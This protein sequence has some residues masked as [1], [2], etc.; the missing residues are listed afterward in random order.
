MNDWGPYIPVDRIGVEPGEP[1]SIPPS[2][3][4]VPRTFTDNEKKRVK[5]DLNFELPFVIEGLQGKVPYSH[6]LEGGIEVSVFLKSKQRAH[7]DIKAALR[8]ADLRP[9]KTG[10]IVSHGDRYGRIN[11]SLIEFE[12]AAF[13]DIEQAGW[14]FE[15]CLN[16]T[17][18]FIEI[19]RRAKQDFTLRRLAKD[20]IFAYIMVHL[21]E[22]S[23]FNE[24]IQPVADL[25]IQALG[26]FPDDPMV[27]PLIWFHSQRSTELWNRLID[28]A[29]HCLSLE[30]Y[31]MAVVNSITALESVLKKAPGTNV[32]EFFERY[33]VPF[34]RWNDRKSRE[35]IT[36]CLN[37]FN[38]LCDKVHLET[39]LTERI[40][41]HY[42][43]RNSIVH[44]GQMN[45]RAEDGQKCVADICSFIRYLLDLIHLSVT[46]KFEI[47]K[48]PNPDDQFEL[49]GMRSDE[50]LLQVN[51][52]GVLFT[53]TLQT[54]DGTTTDVK[55][56]L[57]RAEWTTG[58]TV[59]LSVTYDAHTEAVELLFDT[60]VMDS[61]SGC[62]HGCVDA[63]LLRPQVIDGRQSE[64]L[65]IQA[66]LLHE[67]VVQ[68]DEL[69]DLESF[70]RAPE[71]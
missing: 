70:L 45:V 37:L 46:L 43:R 20:D 63:S 18:R 42:A 14:L 1:I 5:T 25:S 16:W 38:L 13:F 48:L 11:V 55:A 47:V 53:V 54:A 36:V 32:K 19:Y 61:A 68:A 24:I 35:S 9:P 4:Y 17:N 21:Y 71:Q 23:Q 66:I 58:K 52:R 27:K 34:S 59:T 62:R 30:D 51:C 40:L 39:Q 44:S 7:N 26:G 60:T 69:R 33:G 15:K 29:R 31:R 65:S 8:L 56:E 50:M 49:F 10:V 41:K 64:F 6:G 28:E 67:R 22:G 12:V 3:P 57:D 2:G